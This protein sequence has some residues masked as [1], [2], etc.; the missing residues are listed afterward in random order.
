[1]RAP[2]SARPL[3]LIGRSRLSAPT[4]A[5]SLPLSRCPVGQTCRCWFPRMRPLSLS[6]P[7]RPHLSA[8]L[9]LP[10]TISPT[11]TRPRS[12]VLRP[13]PCARAP[14][15]PR[16]LLAHLSYLICALC[17]TLSPS[18]SVCPREHR[19]LPPPAD[20]HCLFRG[21]HHTRAPSSATVSSAL[22][23]AARDTLRCALSLPCVGSALT[24]A[25]F[26]QPEPRR[27]RPEVPLHL[28]RPPRAPEFALEVSTLPMPLFRQVLPQRPRNCSPE[29]ATPPWNLFH[30]DLRSLAPSC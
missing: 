19:A 15:E 16:A 26:A 7:R 17:P 12:R 21:H 18:L 25:A 10:S 29:L 2:A 3:C 30:R 11:W 24:E 23:S 14:F 9:N 13:R 20:A 6:L 8:V 27:R 1:M 4:S 22:L 28:H 5:P